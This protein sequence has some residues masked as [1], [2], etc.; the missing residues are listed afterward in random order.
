MRAATPLCKQRV[1]R[2]RGTLDEQHSAR[3]PLRFRARCRLHV[4]TNQ[5]SLLQQCHH[6]I[7][8]EDDLTSNIVDDDLAPRSQDQEHHAHLQRSKPLGTRCKRR[9]CFRPTARIILPVCNGNNNSTHPRATHV[10]RELH[11]APHSAH[12][13][14]KLPQLSAS[15]QC[16]FVRCNECRMVVLSCDDVW[17]EQ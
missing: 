8:R 5:T 15:V 17:N 16:L 9:R 2:A 11:S 12:T 6:L 14:V 10:L 1:R 7:D 4:Q 13:D 3:P